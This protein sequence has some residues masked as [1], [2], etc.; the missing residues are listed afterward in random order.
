MPMRPV[1]KS[2]DK[3]CLIPA[4]TGRVLR[5]R[6]DL[7]D[8]ENCDDAVE[9]L[10]SRHLWPL[11]DGC[12]LRA[13]ASAEYFESGLRLGRYAALIAEVRD[14]AGE[15]VTVHLTYLAQGRK[16]AT[17]NPRKLLSPVTD[18]TGRAVRLMPIEGDML[19]IA[20]GIETALA[21]AALMQRLQG[22]VTLEILQGFFVM[23]KVIL[24]ESLYRPLD[25]PKSV[26]D[27]LN[28][29]PPLATEIANRWM[30]GL[31]KMVRAHLKSG[32]F[33]KLLK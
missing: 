7:C 12:T 26:Q 24:V 4:P 11:P 13:H 25:Y 30:R 31:P 2:T 32:E 17:Q 8:V 33:L 19:C 18:R 22:K 1:S 10:A 15:L 16:L 21:A 23:R 9:Y 14:K 20:E 29:I 6:L 3:G 28:K 5:L 27:A